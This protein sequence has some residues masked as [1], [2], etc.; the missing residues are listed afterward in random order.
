L[1]NV[2]IVVVDD[3]STDR[4]GEKVAAYPFV[5]YIRHK[6]NLGKGAAVRTGIEQSRGRI[7]VIQD[8]DLEYL[9]DCLPTLVKP[10]IAGEM[11]IV[12]GSRLRRSRRDE[13]FSFYRK[14]LL[15]LMARFLY[16]EQAT[17]IM[18][19]EKRLEGRS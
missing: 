16:S 7:L 9:P 13:F 18:T 11:D 4:T 15:S 10:I 5:K 3:G 19:E 6:R 17:D 8:A 12:Y 1:G 14:S 2:E